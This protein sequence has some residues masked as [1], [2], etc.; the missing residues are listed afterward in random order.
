M[1]SSGSGPQPTNSAILLVSPIVE[2]ESGSRTG[3][4]VSPNLVYAFVLFVC[5]S[6]SG[7]VILGVGSFADKITGAGLL[8]SADTDVVFNT[9]FQL[10][11]WISLLWSTQHDVLGEAK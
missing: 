11:T 8:T 5:C 10:L 4:R 3:L 1:L 6:Q 7:G 9:G 2:Q